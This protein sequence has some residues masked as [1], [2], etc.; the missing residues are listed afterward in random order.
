MPYLRWI[1]WSCWYAFRPRSKD[2]GA[3]LLRSERTAWPRWKFQPSVYHNELGNQWHVCF[4]GD[5]DYTEYRMIGLDVQISVETG[6]IVGLEIFDEMLLPLS[7]RLRAF[8]ALMDE[9]GHAS[10]QVARNLEYLAR[11]PVL[12]KLALDA[13]GARIDAERRKHA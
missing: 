4:S 8:M 3:F 1:F 12:H 6:A 2:L 10:E 13:R 5:R 7:E 11:D 9:F